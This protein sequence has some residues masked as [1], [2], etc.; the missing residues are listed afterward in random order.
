MD[1]FSAD[2]AETLTPID[3]DKDYF[4]E[5]VGEGKRYKAERDLARAVLEKDRHI[6]RVERENAG[7]RTQMQTQEKL[8]EVLDKLNSREP[9]TPNND[10]EQHGRQPDERTAIETP[11]I[12]KLVAEAVQGLTKKQAAEHNLN[13]VTQRLAQEYGE[14]AG[15]TVEQRAREIGV[16]IDFLRSVAAENP[17]AFFRLVGVDD[18]AQT[19]PPQRDVPLPRSSQTFTPK[20]VAAANTWKHYQALQSK[21]K[22]SDY[23]HKDF[24]A[25]IHRDAELLGEAFYD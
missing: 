2:K 22:N 21:M 13:V 10:G 19:Q 3:P 4:P 5:L 6:A 9:L 15:Q 17:K 7:M 23:W 8:E 24:Q 1:I 16:G 12:A 14:N 20:V 18:T 11:D 25:Q